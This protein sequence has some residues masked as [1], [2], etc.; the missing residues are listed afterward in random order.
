MAKFKVNDQV[1]HK[2]YDDVFCIKHIDDYC[3]WI[4]TY[5]TVGFFIGDE[6]NWILMNKEFQIGDL[7]KADNKPFFRR[8]VDKDDFYYW[9]DDEHEHGIPIR[10]AG[11][12]W[13]LVEPLKEPWNP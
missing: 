4:D 6:D 1:K 2:D 5:R 8:I 9:F 11:E 3:Y 13:E 7:I 10:T 12:H